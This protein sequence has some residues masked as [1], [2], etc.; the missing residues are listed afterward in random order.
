LEVKIMAELYCKDCGG[1]GKTIDEVKIETI[2]RYC[3]GLGSIAESQ[4][5]NFPHSK[6]QTENP[7]DLVSKRKVS[8]TKLPA[9]A[10]IYGGAAMMDG[11][12]KYGA[13]NWRSKDVITSIYVDAA[14][15]HL[16]AWFEGE[17]NASDS[18][19][20][21]LGHV[22]ACCAILLDAQELGKL[23][24]DR[25]GIIGHLGVASRVLERLEK[26]NH[27]PNKMLSEDHS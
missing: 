9:V 12:G 8:L 27:K 7:K 26:N 13:Y 23:K 2:C 10:H 4:D 20:H 11:A 24:D 5:F 19:V 17:E 6:A 21:H 1:R 15:R 25:P 22:I 14:F 16:H 18:G 3:N